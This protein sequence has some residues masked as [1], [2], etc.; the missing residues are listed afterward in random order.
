MWRVS[1]RG[2]AREARGRYRRRVAARGGACDAVY[3]RSWLGFARDWLFCLSMPFLLQLNAQNVD[4]PVLQVLW[5]LTSDSDDWMKARA[6]E[7]RQR[8]PQEPES[9]RNGF[10]TILTI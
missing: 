6:A 2:L 4:I 1:E 9:Q 7:E 10:D 3:G 8:C 5:W